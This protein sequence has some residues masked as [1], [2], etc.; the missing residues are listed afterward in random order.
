VTV[1]ASIPPTSLPIGQGN[2][3]PAVDIPV[4]SNQMLV[5]VTKMGWLGTDAKVADFVLSYAANGGPAVEIMRADVFDVSTD[6]NP[7]IFAATIPDS[8][9]GRRRLIL[10]WE[11]L[12]ARQVAGSIE[13]NTV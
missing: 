2:I 1:I 11:F 7:I 12:A 13:A 3:K 5:K 9:N 6:A 8:V 10:S 4:G